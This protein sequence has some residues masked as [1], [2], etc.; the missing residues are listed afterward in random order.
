MHS[1]PAG[2]LLLLL[3][4]CALLEDGEPRA[5]GGL[6]APGCYPGR[7]TPLHLLSWGNGVP[8]VCLKAGCGDTALG[9]TSE[10]AGVLQ[11]FMSPQPN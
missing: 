5:G 10:A 8:G 6:G 11:S 9:A 7:G 4:L 3:A 2:V 1:H